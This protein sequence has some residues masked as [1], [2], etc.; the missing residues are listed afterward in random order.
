MGSGPRVSSGVLGR[1]WRS[2]SAMASATTA[3]RMSETLTAMRIAR[4][5]TGSK[6]GMATWL[7]PP[8]GIARDDVAGHL[9]LLINAERPVQR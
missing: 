5:R 6:E 7:E 1:G 9:L 2:A 3:I 4:T 8:A